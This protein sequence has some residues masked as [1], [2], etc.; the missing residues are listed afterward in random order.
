[1][2]WLFN[3]DAPSRIFKQELNILGWNYPTRKLNENWNGKLRNQWWIVTKPRYTL[4]DPVCIP[5][6]EIIHWQFLSAIIMSTF[7]ILSVFTVIKKQSLSWDTLDGA[8]SAATVMARRVLITCILN[9][10]HEMYILLRCALLC[11]W[12]SY[13]F[14]SFLV[15]HSLRSFRVVSLYTSDRFKFKVKSRLL[16]YFRAWCLHISHNTHYSCQQHLE[17]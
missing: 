7:D 6:H 16:P 4:H 11:F 9:T 13:Q 17:Q 3:Q 10:S 15:N 1:M 2:V 5:I 14:L 12:L 8:V